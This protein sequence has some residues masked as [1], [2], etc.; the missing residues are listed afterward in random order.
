MPNFLKNFFSADELK[1]SVLV[2][3]YCINSLAV[4]VMS[5]S[6][7]T[8]PP[9]FETLML[10]QLTAITGLN[11]TKQIKDGSNTSLDVP[12]ETK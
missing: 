3:T 7:K 2:V 4:V 6:S 8:I 1:V 5:W 11:I 12:E 9:I 10:A